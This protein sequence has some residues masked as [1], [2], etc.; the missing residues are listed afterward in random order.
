M[1]TVTAL[2]VNEL[3]GMATET[4]MVV[5]SRKTTEMILSGAVIERVTTFKLLV[6]F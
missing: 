5:N 2:F 1:E 6:L 4:G 3:V